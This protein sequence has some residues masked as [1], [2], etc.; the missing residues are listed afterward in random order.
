MKQRRKR[1]MN[2]GNQKINKKRKKEVTLMKIKYLGTGASEGIPALFCRC[3]ICNEA[4]KRGGK[5]LRSRSQA[6]IDDQLLV[7]FPAD[8]YYHIQK[9]NLDFSSIKTLLITHS[10]DDHF[11]PFDLLMRLPAYAH[12]MGEKKLHIYGNHEVG[13]Y[14]KEAADRFS[15]SQIWEFIE[16]HEVKI[17]E[18]FKVDSYTVYPLPARHMK[19]ENALIYLIEGGGKTLL[20]GNDTGLFYDEVWDFLKNRKIDCVSL[21]CTMGKHPTDPAHMGF[22][23]DIDIQER[24][25]EMN[26][27][28]QYTKWVCVH[29]SHNGGMLYKEMKEWAA[30]K[31]FEAAWDGMEIKF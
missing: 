16:Y 31:N 29:F 22:P 25:N 8:S 3:P 17:F 10:H 12:N 19:N 14:L 4:R 30:E 11:Y 23:N 13:C 9:Y 24:L 21:D 18:S 26:C 28:N 6:I 7:D 20:Y 1:W 27:T 15:V 5:E 2:I